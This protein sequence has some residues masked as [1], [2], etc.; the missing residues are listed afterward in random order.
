AGSR[1][2]MNCPTT[3]ALSAGPSIFSTTSP[4]TRY[5]RGLTMPA[6]IESCHAWVGPAPQRYQGV[7]VHHDDSAWSS[8]AAAVADVREGSFILVGAVDENEVEF[9][10]CLAARV[11][12]GGH[13]R[14]RVTDH[15]LVTP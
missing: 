15:E 13:G 14:G 1:D 7:V 5:S 4:S 6:A 9:V 11:S 2:Q 10:H 3:Q 8:E 12:V